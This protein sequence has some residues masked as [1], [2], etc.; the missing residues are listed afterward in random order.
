MEPYGATRGKNVM[1]DF[2]RGVPMA[3]GVEN[4]FVFAEKEDRKRVVL[5]VSVKF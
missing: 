4:I 2:I 5:C 3:R 1:C